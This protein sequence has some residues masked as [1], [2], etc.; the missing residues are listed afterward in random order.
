MLALTKVETWN[1]EFRDSLLL[2]SVL[3]YLS[4]EWALQS[5]QT[6]T[7]QNMPFYFPNIWVSCNLSGEIGQILFSTGSIGYQVE[8]LRAEAGND[9]IVD[10]ATRVGME[11][12]R[13]S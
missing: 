10:N 9:G 3:K 2:Q 1:V 7:I 5:H 4:A 8:R 6:P 11:E 13:K 12:T